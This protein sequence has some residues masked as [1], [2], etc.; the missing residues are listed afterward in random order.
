MKVTRARPVDYDKAVAAAKERAPD[1]PVT[2]V[3]LNKV[4]G[5]RKVFDNYEFIADVQKED[6]FR[7]RIAAAT[8]NGFRYVVLRE[9]YYHSKSDSWRPGKNGLYI[10]M[11]VPTRLNGGD[12]PQIVDVG[13]TFLA[14]FMK[15]MEVAKTMPLAD[16]NNMLYILPNYTKSTSVRAKETRNNEDQQP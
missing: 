9:F 15:A 6:R 16:D 1:R 7:T 11:F 2:P 8:L 12:V 4:Y 10:P 3:V 13:D 14:N 5:V